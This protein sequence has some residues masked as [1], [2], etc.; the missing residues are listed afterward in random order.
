MGDARRPALHLAVYLHDPQPFPGCYSLYY[1]LG[2]YTVFLHLY[3]RFHSLPGPDLNTV[4]TTAVDVTT[5]ITT[6]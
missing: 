6:G 2:L 5:V 3:Y 1:S 4:F